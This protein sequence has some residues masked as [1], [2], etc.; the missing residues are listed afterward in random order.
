MKIV[1]INEV[2][3]ELAEILKEIE[4]SV[5]SFDVLDDLG[6]WFYTTV[7]ATF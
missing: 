3:K 6:K 5:A 1:Y 4:K 2:E 7:R